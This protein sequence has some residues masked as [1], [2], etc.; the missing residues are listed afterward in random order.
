MYPNP[1]HPATYKE[2][3]RMEAEILKM[4]ASLVSQSPDQNAHGV[5][6]SGGS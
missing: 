3:I 1:L 2:L 5:I 4:T 6:T